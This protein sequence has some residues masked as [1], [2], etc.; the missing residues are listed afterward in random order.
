MDDDDGSICNGFGE[1][2][3]IN[4][5]IKFGC[6]CRTQEIQEQSA[7]TPELIFRTAGA[8]NGATEKRQI[9]EAEKKVARNDGSAEVAG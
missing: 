3:K 1:G 6:C 8:N 5:F 2:V 4:N 9:Y 7:L